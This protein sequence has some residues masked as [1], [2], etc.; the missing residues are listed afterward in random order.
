MNNE[1]YW[2]KAIDLLI[3]T[4]S[5]NVGIGVSIDNRVISLVANLLEEHDKLKQD[6]LIYKKS[7]EMYKSW[8]GKL[9]W[10][11]NNLNMELNR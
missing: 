10:Q 2:Y 5:F 7:N 1:E 8:I 4:N 3:A 9:K 11:I 6:L